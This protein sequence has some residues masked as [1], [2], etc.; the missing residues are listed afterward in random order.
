M[1]APNRDKTTLGFS[2]SR[3]VPIKPCKSTVC[4]IISYALYACN[5]SSRMY[6]LKPARIIY[7]IWFFPR[8]ISWSHKTK[9]PHA[10]PAITSWSCVRLT[11]SPI[12]WVWVGILPK[13]NRVDRESESGPIL[14]A[15]MFNSTAVSKWQRD[16][17][18][19]DWID[20]F[21]SKNI[22]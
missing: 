3:G 6:K 5:N 12:D 16:V 20:W 4:L 2:V 10:S 7:Q 8:L 14:T 17:T 9:T 22:L 15:T 13:P 21:T 11:L 19:L 1:L 18:G